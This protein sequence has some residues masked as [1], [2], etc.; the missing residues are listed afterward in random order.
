MNPI[1]YCPNCD[2]EYELPEDIEEC[3][4]CGVDELEEI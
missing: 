4:I 1:Y 2:E 3:P